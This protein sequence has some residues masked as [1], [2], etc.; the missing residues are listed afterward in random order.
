[1][2]PGSA[3]LWFPSGPKRRQLGLRISALVLEPWLASGTRVLNAWVVDEQRV[4]NIESS[5]VSGAFG[6]SPLAGSG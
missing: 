2:G 5:P 3:G 6:V 4:C 1:M